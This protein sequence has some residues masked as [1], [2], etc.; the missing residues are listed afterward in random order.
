MELETKLSSS[1][2]RFSFNKTRG[3]VSYHRH[4]C[5]KIALPMRTHE[6]QT[7][8]R[9]ATCPSHYSM[10]RTGSAI[11]RNLTLNSKGSGLVESTTTQM[12]RRQRWHRNWNRR[13]RNEE[14]IMQKEA[15]MNKIVG[16]VKPV[17]GHC[18]MNRGQVHDGFYLCWAWCGADIQRSTA[19]FIWETLRHLQRTRAV[20]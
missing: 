20:R 18:E 15:N 5:R 8:T 16:K 9:I 12:E 14:V 13:C 2:S 19:V 6:Y 7:G 3:R 17:G 11:H 1:L 4:P 10:V